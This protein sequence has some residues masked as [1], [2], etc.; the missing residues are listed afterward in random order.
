MDLICARLEH[1]PSYHTGYVCDAYVA[2]YVNKSIE[3]ISNLSK[4]IK[5]LVESCIEAE[6]NYV[7][8]VSHLGVKMHTVEISAQKAA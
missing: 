7:A 5:A 3:G 6:L 2:K 4:V 1:G 8:A